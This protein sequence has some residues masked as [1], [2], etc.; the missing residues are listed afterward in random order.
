MII[1]HLAREKSTIEHRSNNIPHP[2]E[3]AVCAQPNISHKEDEI[4]NPNFE[5]GPSR[6]PG[7]DPEEDDRKPAA[8]RIRKEPEDDAQRVTQDEPQEETTFKHWDDEMDYEAIFRK[9]ISIGDDDK[10]HYNVVDME[11]DAQRAVRRIQVHQEI[12]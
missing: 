11:R 4:Q 2:D 6:L 3:N 5:H 1:I 12:A 10:D 8:E 9:Y 7:E